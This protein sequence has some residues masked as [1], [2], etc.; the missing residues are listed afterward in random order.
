MSSPGNPVRFSARLASVVPSVPGG[1]ETVQQGA[2]DEASAAASGAGGGVCGALP[3]AGGA[4]RGNARRVAGPGRGGIACRSIT[5]LVAH[6]RRQIDHVERRLLRG[7]TIPHEEKVF[8]IFEEH[9]RWV[10][11]GKAGT[12]VELGVPVA[13]IEDQY[14]FILHHKVLWEGE[15]VD[16][17]VSMVQGAQ[18]LYPELRA[19]SFDRGFHSRD[20]RV[21]LDALLDVNALPGRG[22]LSRADR[23]REEEESFVAARRA[24]PAIESAINGLDH[25]GLDRV[26]S[27]GADGFART[28]AL[29]V[30][31]ANL[32]RIGL[33]LQKRE[34]KRQ[35]L[36]A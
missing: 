17:A 5:G 14:G 35:R 18:A 7:E 19:C 12:P 31:A 24:H 15:D 30:L 29:S 21:R 36:V 9:T 2:L 32:H 1:Q 4:S 25:R 8:S 34:R 10:S 20:N 6:A 28:V 27:H 22:Y 3:G 11:K 16:V 13:I 26:R 33:I 23:E